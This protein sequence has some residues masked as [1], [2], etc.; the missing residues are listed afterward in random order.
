MPYLQPNCD[1]MMITMSDNMTGVP[2]CATGEG[3]CNNGDGSDNDDNDDEE[4]NNDGGEWWR[5]IMV[6]Y[7]TC[8]ICSI[9]N[10]LHHC[11]TSDSS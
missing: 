8:S 5:R 10:V 9:N 4:E 3:N 6:F 7:Q 1:A 2:V 11:P